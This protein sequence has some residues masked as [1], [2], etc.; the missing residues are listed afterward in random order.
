MQTQHH[1][2]QSDKTLPLISFII[3]YYNE[4]IDMIKKCIDSILKLTLSAEEREIIVIDDGSDNS[5]LSLLA[6]IKPETL[7]LQWQRDNIFSL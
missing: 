5:P 7:V 4:P 1:L 3:T 6:E 2:P